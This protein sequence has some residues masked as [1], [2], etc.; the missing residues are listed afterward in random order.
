MIITACFPA[1][2]AIATGFLVEIMARTAA[3]IA[4]LYDEYEKSS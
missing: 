4:E 1:H 3:F 2:A